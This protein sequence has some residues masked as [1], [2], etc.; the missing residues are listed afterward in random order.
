M[1]RYESLAL[2]YY[3]SLI[4]HKKIFTLFL[5]TGRTPGKD[6]LSGESVI[7]NLTQHNLSCSTPNTGEAVD[8]SLQIYA[9]VAQVV[10]FGM[11]HLS[12]LLAF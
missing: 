10:F 6:R 7:G 8:Q 5:Y 12:F 9:R 11:H 2:S 4:D 1:Y 3:T